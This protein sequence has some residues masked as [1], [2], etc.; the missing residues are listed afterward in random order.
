LVTAASDLSPYN[1]IVDNFRLTKLAGFARAEVEKQKQEQQLLLQAT[2]AQ[3]DESSD[4]DIEII[5]SNV[6]IFA[7]S[8]YHL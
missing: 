1:K 6:R 4:D 7:Y 2:A 3:E 5:S 8:A